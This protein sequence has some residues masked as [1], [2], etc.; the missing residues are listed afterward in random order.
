AL[1]PVCSAAQSTR[2]MTGQ[3]CF[4][5]RSPV[6]HP[7]Q[8]FKKYVH[9]KVVLDVNQVLTLNA[10]LQPGATQETIEVSSQAPLVDTTSTQLG[11]VV[12]DR[13]ISQLPLNVL[14]T[15]QFLQLQPGVMSTT[16]SRNQ[17]VYVSAK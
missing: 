12:D 10:I 2:R 6:K 11:A 9:T 1:P 17:I 4:A 7:L 13:T 3:V 14:D 15:Y 8:E 16:G 5:D